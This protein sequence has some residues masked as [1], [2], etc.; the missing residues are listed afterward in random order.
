MP[1]SPA[2]K[3]HDSDC[4]IA[5]ALD[6]FGD[7]WTLL[8]IRDLMLRGEATYGAFLGAGEGIATNVL[9]DRLRALE[10]AGII[11][12]TQDPDNRRRKLY[13]LTPKG[14]D[15]APV[16]LEIIRWSDV[17]D[18]RAGTPKDLARRIEKDREGVLADIRAG[19]PVS[20]RRNR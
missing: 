7:R 16:I 14:L 11:T 4:P 18:H 15:L 13:S 9:A 20:R 2:A 8:I 5:F 10:A 6:I 19:R 17:H 12:A 1:R 3:I